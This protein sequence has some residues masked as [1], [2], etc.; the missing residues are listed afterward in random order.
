MINLMGMSPYGQE[1]IQ[2]MKGSNPG[3]L[4]AASE[5]HI[6]IQKACLAEFDQKAGSNRK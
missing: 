6:Y 5:D 3:R 2:M 4:L 1:M